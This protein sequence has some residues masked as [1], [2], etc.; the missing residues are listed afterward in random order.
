MLTKKT[1]AEIVSRHFKAIQS[2]PLSGQM[3][4]RLSQLQSEIFHDVE[5]AADETGLA[6]RKTETGSSTSGAGKGSGKGAKPN[7]TGDKTGDE[8]KGGE[9]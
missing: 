4:R 3:S 5:R 1:I 6:S 9:N 8:N 7:E 2:E